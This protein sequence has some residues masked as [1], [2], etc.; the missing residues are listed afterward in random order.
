VKTAILIEHNAAF[1]RLEVEEIVALSLHARTADGSFVGVVTRPPSIDLCNITNPRTIAIWWSA[2]DIDSRARDL[3]IILTEEQALNILAVMKKQHSADQGI[4]WDVIDTYIDV[5]ATSENNNC[6]EGYRCP[7]CGSQSP[8]LMDTECVMK[9]TDDGT[10][11]QGKYAQD[12]QI[13]GA[14]SYTICCECDHHDST[15]RFRIENQK[16]AETV[17]AKE[18]E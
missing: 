11:S 9:W 7:K 8:F 17:D 5:A 10:D 18:T 14:G 13:A 4:N 2:G 16:P 1:S 15:Y 12:M 3:G 6:L